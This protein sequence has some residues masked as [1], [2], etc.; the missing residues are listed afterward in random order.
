MSSG[1]VAARIDRSRP[2]LA[3]D[4]RGFRFPAF[5]HARLANGLD[6]YLAR[7]PYYPVA[8][9]QLLLPAGGQYQSAGE[10]GLASLQGALLDEGT[11]R[12]SALEIASSIERLGGYLATA[13]DWDVTHVGATV[14]AP[15]LD[16]ALELVAELG[17]R[18]SFPAAE[19]ERARRQRL[20]EILRA[21]GQPASLAERFCARAIYAGTPYGEPLIGTEESVERLDR[22]TCAG[23][24][25]RQAGPRGAALIAVGDLDPERLGRRIEAV[26][27]DW[28]GGPGSELPTI[29]PRALSGLE[30]HIVDRPAAPQTQ[31][32]LGHPGLPR[33]HPEHP[34]ALVANAILGS[35]FTSRLNLNLR[36]KHGITYGA[37]SQF[38]YRQATGPF[39]IRVAVATASVATAVREILFEMERLRDE[40]VPPSELRETQDFLMGVF[41]ITLQTVADLAKR[42]ELLALYDLGDDYY[43]RYPAVISK[44]TS[45]SVRAAARRYFRPDRIAVVAVGPAEELRGQLAELGPVEVWQP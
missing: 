11:A 6:L 19:V 29:E 24:Y 23:F 22:D 4:V 30:V 31:L 42:L 27:G 12:L 41:P 13:A 1:Q 36:E 39:V 35:K 32:Q 45:D 15:H 43:A 38:L 3:N 14:L 44:A 37:H 9:L 10:A 34:N 17:R 7:W 40:P 2:P 8:N 18:P 21:K 28:Q 26:F 25:R 20:A 16:A 33:D 5:Q